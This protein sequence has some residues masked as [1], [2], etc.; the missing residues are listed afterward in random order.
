[1]VLLHEL[2]GNKWKVE[3]VAYGAISN[4]R[5]DIAIYA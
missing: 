4:A 5:R 3:R 1:M 2:H